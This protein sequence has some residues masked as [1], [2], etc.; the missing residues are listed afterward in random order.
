M[1]AA[2]FASSQGHGSFESVDGHLLWSSAGWIY[3][4]G[5]RT[6]CGAHRAADS[7]GVQEFGMEM[8]GRW[9]KNHRKN[10]CNS[11]LENYGAHQNMQTYLT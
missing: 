3:D 5:P 4:L 7:G 1:L 11:G 6:S 9:K 2:F 8:V 10:I